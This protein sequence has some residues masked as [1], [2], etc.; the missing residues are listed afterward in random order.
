MIIKDHP[1]SS[2]VHPSRLELC[3]TSRSI[4]IFRFSEDQMRVVVLSMRTSYFFSQASRS[5]SGRKTCLW[6]G[7]VLTS[8]CLN[9]PQVS[10]HHQ[11]RRG[12]KTHTSQQF[13]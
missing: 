10:P 11:A 13:L 6:K 12:C 2:R 5:F 7:S 4:P 8:T 9:L 1:C 3:D